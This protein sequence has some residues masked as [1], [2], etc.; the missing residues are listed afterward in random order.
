M[1]NENTVENRRSFRITET[2]YLKYEVISDSEFAAGID[3]RKLRN[4]A[5]DGVRSKLLDLDT[6]LDEKLYVLRS[7]SGT[8]AECLN[9]LNR[10]INTVIQQLPETKAS[11][12]SLAR[13]SPQTCE[14]GA[15]GMAFATEKNYAVHTKL[16]LRLLLE[17]D[18]R[19][20]ETF[21]EVVRTMD[22]PGEID[23]E[24][25]FGV[26]VEFKGMKAAQK[27]III[28]HLFHR[29]SESLRLRRLELDASSM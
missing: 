17:S 19:Y 1:S 2:V 6:R 12:S 18:N 14:L 3:R 26:A 28:Q 10:K 24:R 16:A 8:I 22:P 23:V 15:D 7:E 5:S 20:I 11:K 21:C 29:E 13:S 25:P 9:I 4:G 27:E